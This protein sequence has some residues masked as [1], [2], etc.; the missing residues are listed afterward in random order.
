MRLMDVVTV[1]LYVNLDNDI[2]M[3]ISEG[4]NMPEAYNFGPREN[5][6]MKL[7]KSLYVLK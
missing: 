7:Q 2:Y 3:K 5:Y 4:F 1:Y 6:S